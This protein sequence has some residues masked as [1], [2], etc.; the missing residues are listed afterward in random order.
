MPKIKS[1]MKQ[2]FQ[3][4]FNLPKWS[5]F[6]C[7]R[8]V[9]SSVWWER[10]V[11]GYSGHPVAHLPKGSS[12]SLMHQ[13]KNFKWYLRCLRCFKIRSASEL[14]LPSGFPRKLPIILCLLYLRFIKSVDDAMSERSLKWLSRFLPHV[15]RIYDAFQETESRPVWWLELT[16]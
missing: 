12:G 10:H 6:P 2:T 13:H 9:Y 14:E 1:S 5:M 4:Y 8:R 3:G 16:F 15:W 7:E 11:S